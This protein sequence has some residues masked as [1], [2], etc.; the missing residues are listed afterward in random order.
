[1]KKSRNICLICLAVSDVSMVDFNVYLILM[2]KD[3]ICNK[4][5]GFIS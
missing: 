4:L 1:M 3:L 5:D 2:V